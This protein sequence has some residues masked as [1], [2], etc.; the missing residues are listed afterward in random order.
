MSKTQS[1]DFFCVCAFTWEEKISIIKIAYF[2]Q[3]VL[4]LKSKARHLFF[5]LASITHPVWTLFLFKS[6]WT[7]SQG[8]QGCQKIR[9]FFYK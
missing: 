1:A 7:R 4:N 8:S 3:N 2:M 5:G 6:I 9:I